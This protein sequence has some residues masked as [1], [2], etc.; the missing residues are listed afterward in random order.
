MDT[1]GLQARLFLLYFQNCRADAQELKGIP[2]KQAH[3]IPHPPVTLTA[4]QC[5]L[6][7]NFILLP[8]CFVGH[9]GGNELFLLCCSSSG[10]EWNQGSVAPGKLNLLGNT[11][12]LELMLFKQR[13]SGR[14][15]RNPK[16]RSDLP[17]AAEEVSGT[18]RAQ[19]AFWILSCYLRDSHDLRDSHEWGVSRLKP[20]SLGW[21]EFLT[22][23]WHFKL[24]EIPG[25]PLVPQWPLGSRVGCAVKG[26]PHYGGR[27]RHKMP[28]QSIVVSCHQQ[29]PKFQPSHTWD[30]QSQ[31]I[32]SREEF[33]VTLWWRGTGTS[34]RQDDFRH[35]APVG[36]ECLPCNIAL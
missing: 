8:N 22:L 16:E 20:V 23:I 11:P 32:N 14:G 4:R 17:Q 27:Q 12:G 33:C 21:A 25:L 1:L 13:E 6:L 34:Q 18:G 3:L 15:S 30:V 31:P 9:R 10:P 24:H 36:R 26:S 2:G 28:E 7:I 29:N 35:I 19:G 5:H